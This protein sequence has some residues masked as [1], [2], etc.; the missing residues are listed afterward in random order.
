MSNVI[1]FDHPLIQHKLTVLRKT[2]TGSKEFRE[3]IINEYETHEQK[4]IIEFW[5]GKNQGRK[6]REEE[7]NKNKQKK[8]K[9]KRNR[10]QN[11][12]TKSE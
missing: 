7:Q 6:K 8:T 12:Q 9:Q 2:E 10:K 1:V 11:K 4:I 5:I 3:L